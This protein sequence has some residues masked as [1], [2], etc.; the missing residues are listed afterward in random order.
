MLVF[1]FRDLSGLFRKREEIGAST[2]GGEAG[3][4]RGGGGG[5]DARVGEAG[6]SAAGRGTGAG[7]GRAGGGGVATTLPSTFLE[8]WAPSS[9][10][11]DSRR[12]PVALVRP[13]WPPPIVDLSPPRAYSPASWFSCS[14]IS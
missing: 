7:V 10:V 13:P 5:G 11:D 14:R 2:T 12:K 1:H 8:D 3:G 4:G 9:G 6:E